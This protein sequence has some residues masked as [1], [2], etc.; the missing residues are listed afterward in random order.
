[1]SCTWAG[2]CVAGGFYTDAAGKRQAFLVSGR[3]GMWG[4]AVEVPGMATLNQ[5]AAGV[6]SVSCAWPGNCV[7]GGSYTGA[8]GQRQAFVVSE[9]HGMW[10]SAIE[11][12]G[13]GALNKG[14][15]AAVESVS[16]GW[17][18]NCAAGGYY[19]PTHTVVNLQAF[20]VSES[21]G[22]WHTA[23]EVPGTGALNTAQNAAVE[24]VSCASAGSC[25][26]GG[27]YQQP[28][29]SLAFVDSESNGT[30]GTAIEVPGT[31]TLAKDGGV[32]VQSVSCASAGNCTAGGS[33]QAVKQQ[34]WVASETNGTWGAAIEVPGTGVL[35][36]GGQAGTS[37]VSCASWGGC[38][39][40]GSYRDSS[41]NYQ[42]FGDSES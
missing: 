7:A 2:N 40:G 20:V 37:S 31:A 36:Q 28:T 32:V 22:T 30:W 39:I 33:Y 5:G 15:Y 26:A 29:G 16:C 14:G 24:S 10:G 8:A 19:S 27:F 13:T 9:R 4:A 12:P 21:N 11:V 25:V 41:G 42:V 34:A 23:I 38:A 35:N 3:H 18:G 1:V 17:A 6:S